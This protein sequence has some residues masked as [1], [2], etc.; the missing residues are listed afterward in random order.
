MGNGATVA[1]SDA[2]KQHIERLEN[3]N[4][5]LKES[6]EHNMLQFTQKIESLETENK[7]LQEKLKLALF[8]QFGRAA[9]RFDGA[10]QPQLFDSED[11]CASRTGAGP[12]ETETIRYTRTK[13]R[14]RKPID[15]KLPR[16]TVIIDLPEA[17]QQCACGNTLTC[18]GEDVAERLVLI[19]EQ[20]YVI[21]YRT[22]K[23]AC[24]VCE[25]SGDE[26]KPAVRSGKA[27]A[28]LM[29]GSIATPELLSYIFTKKYCD[30][31]PYYRQEAAFERIGVDLPRQTMNNWQLKTTE[32]LR[33]LLA[34]LRGQLRKGT[35]VQMDET[36]M[37][38]MDEPG[39]KNSQESRMWLARGGPPEEPVLWYEYQATR[40]KKHIV[41]LLAGFSGYLQSDGYCSYESAT[42]KD[43]TG[44]IHVGCFAHVRRHFFEAQKI[45]AKPGLADEA[46]S[47]IQELYKAE[48][49]LRQK[50]RSETI[51]AE[52]FAEDR[53]AVCAPKLAAFHEW[54]AAHEHAAPPSSKIGEAIAY[55]LKQWPSLTRYLDDW[56]LT[57]DNNACERGIRPF[58][59]G[60]KN[61]VMSGSPAG[62]ASSCELYTLIETA[63]ANNWNP[64]KYLTK[65]F[66]RAAGMSP[67]NDWS[68]LLPWSLPK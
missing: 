1:A 59:M 24:H 6:L 21:Q 35:V 14:G 25:G 50:L 26:G 23:Y 64:T 49:E 38:V 43:L 57:P 11:A 42:K 54:L 29:P 9:E 2:V 53:R 63:K 32:K 45:T 18:I 28:S 20:V 17:E 66:Q 51:S 33:P 40:E 13:A 30:Y 60:R 31:T 10:G 68:L 55:A 36:P 47:Q 34:L 62:A 16:E 4:R 48:R 15:P 46:L 7:R 8:R 44:V 12:A 56:Q 3:E 67:D 65:V 5:Q 22:K 37:Q 58:V 39:R 41:E 61:W 52:Q 19:P 27:P